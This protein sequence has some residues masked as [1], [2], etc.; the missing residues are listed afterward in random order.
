MIKKLFMAYYNNFDNDNAW[1]EEMATAAT[2]HQNKVAVAVKASA[3]ES[4]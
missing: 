1:T 4:E 2:E 3:D